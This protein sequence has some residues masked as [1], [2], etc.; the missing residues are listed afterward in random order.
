[1]GTGTGT[2]VPPGTGTGTGTVV[3]PGTGTGTGTIAPPGTG[4]DTVVP[5][6]TGTGTGTVVPP[7]T[8]TDTVVPPGTGTGTG[9]VVPP[10]TGTGTGTAAPP[11]TGTGTG[12]VVP[13]GTG[14]DTVVPPGTGTGTGTVA[15]PGTGTGTG[16]VA[17]PGTGTGTDTVAPPGT[18]TGTETGGPPATGTGT[19]TVA[20][21]GTGTNA[22]PGTGT[23]TQ[24]APV[25]TGPGG[26]TT[27]GPPITTAAYTTDSVFPPLAIV[28]LSSATQDGHTVTTGKDGKPTPVPIIGGSHCW[29]CPPGLHFYLF[30]GLL[31][32]NIYPPGPPPPGWKNPI[33]GLTID[34]NGNPIY[35]PK[36]DPGPDPTKPNPSQPSNSASETNS[37]CTARTAS[38]CATTTI[39]PSAGKRAA[40]TTSK[41]CSA[42]ATGCDATATST[43]TSVASLSRIIW[44]KDGTD[45]GQTGSIFDDIASYVDK[46][47]IYTSQSK[48]L[49]VS[50]WT[51]PLTDD[52]VDDLKKKNTNIVL[53]ADAGCPSAGCFD[54]T[55]GKINKAR[56]GNLHRR[57]RTPT[58]PSTTTNK[59][60]KVLHKRADIF[61]R[62]SPAASE[63]VF[64]SQPTNVPLNALKPR[65]VYEF[66]GGTDQ[67]V[68][69]VDTG[70]ALDNK[71]FTSGSNIASRVRWLYANSKIDQPG[72]NALFHGT[73]MLSKAC[74]DQFGVAKKINPVVVRVP[75][76][77]AS[78]EDY[79]DGVQAAYD[80][81]V[82]Q[83]LKNAALS[84]SWVYP[85]G[86]PG[87]PQPWV[88][89]LE[90]LL[91]NCVG[92]GLLPVPVDG[93]PALFGETA[94][95]EMMV[96]GAVNNDGTLALKSQTASW[97]TVHA[98]GVKV[99]CAWQ[100]GP[101]L[102]PTKEATGTS[103]ATATVA[104]LVA[105]FWGLAS[106]ANQLNLNG[107]P[108]D[109]VIAM[110]AYVEALAYSRDAG[111]NLPHAI[112]NGID[113]KNFHFNPKACP[114]E[115]RDDTPPPGSDCTAPDVDASSGTGNPA[116]GTSNTAGNKATQTA[117]TTGAPVDWSCSNPSPEDGDG[118]CTCHVGSKTTVITQSGGPGNSC[119][120]TVP[121]GF[122]PTG[123]QTTVPK[124]TAPPATTQAPSWGCS[125]PSVED[126]DGLCTCNLGSK[127][128]VITPAGG[129][130]NTCPSSAP[131]GFASTVVPI[132]PSAPT[133]GAEWSCGNPSPED[134]DGLCH[135]NIGS[136]TTVFTQ[137]GGPGNLCPTTAPPGF[138]PTGQPT[139]VPKTTAPPATTQAPSW[140]CTN[141]SL[142]DGD[143]LCTCNLGS[144][145]TV[146]TPA[147]GPGN[148]CPSSAPPGF[149]PTAAARFRRGYDRLGFA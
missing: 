68:Y 4:T 91:K 71:E 57:E 129:P 27:Q 88:D 9:T 89:R 123:Q 139:T 54:P 37:A 119:P 56:L 93:H 142:E 128:T 149:A 49:G 87:A 133:G 76:F 61:T 28:T 114:K 31:P 144:K 40:C 90:V 70:A 26:I 51:A 112:W 8:G 17:P 21:P 102:E 83:G 29:F 32:D 121:P 73:C 100:P 85:K 24:G 136:K 140:G 82:S 2:V 98:P 64:I 44:P 23:A 50:Y 132:A 13:P 30:G 22:P 66:S 59:P 126:G 97:V 110:K 41:T 95:P 63:M 3:P 33:P 147:G 52:Q 60:D 6:G 109:R 75:Q 125:N 7:G 113:A 122:A 115:K 124:T 10:G 101:D 20:P 55:L 47:K 131:P 39:C 84:L 108:S 5:P 78:A 111:Q 12:T 25:T 34:P 103:P 94:I 72:D 69:I 138:A 86:T 16:T 77:S 118:L 53:V 11:G 143:G 120:T 148:T 58:A 134:G 141:P 67:T 79:L 15:P 38:R 35:P 81:Y 45:G 74:G 43:S 80:D 1:T 62:Q 135:C 146:I 14:T 65:Y 18:G 107:S 46:S 48:Y 36:P 96:I 92:H 105:Y 99:E 106:I 19:G 42:V 130:G 127:S 137:S 116:T 145:S 104:G 117:G